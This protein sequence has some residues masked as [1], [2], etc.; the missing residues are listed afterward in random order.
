MSTENID[1]NIG[2]NVTNKILQFTC[3]S[4][5]NL[6]SSQMSEAMVCSGVQYVT[7]QDMLRELSNITS[8]FD[9]FQHAFVSVLTQPSQ[10]SN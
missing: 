10:Q 3:S 7:R 6:P 2:L 8:R 1:N 4:G 5:Q 9:D